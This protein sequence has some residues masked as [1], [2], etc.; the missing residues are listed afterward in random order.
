MAKTEK[1]DVLS[2]AKQHINQLFKKQSS[3]KLVY[4]T[5]NHTLEI[6]DVCEDMAQYYELSQ[7]DKEI[8]MLA[9][10]FQNTGYMAD[11]RD[12]DN[13]SIIIAEDFLM[14]L[15]YP[16]EKL[17]RVLV[18]I[19][20]SSLTD[21][22]GNLLQEILHDANLMHI[23]KKD[24]FRKGT[25]LRIE[26]E[27]NL[28]ESHTA[29]EWEQIELDFLLDNEFFTQYAVE[30]F[31]SRRAKNIKKQHGNLLK[32]KQNRK[33]KK[34]GKSFGRGIETLYRA[35]YRNHINLSSIADAKANMM[36]SINTIIMSVIITFAGTGFTISSS[37]MIERYRFI[38][39]IMVLL[40]A[41]LIS[42]VFAV[43]SA[44]PKVTEKT[45]TEKK[46]KERKSS[47]LFFGNFTQIPL[48]KFVEF[49][50]N[51]K[52]DQKLLYDNMSVDIY[53]LGLVLERKYKLLRIS[54]NTFMGGLVISVLTF[55]VIFIYT[56]T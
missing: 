14:E 23:G 53:Y 51:F 26:V 37:M 18:L 56:T 42:V 36:I 12:H 45:M 7:R 33:K 43:L 6:L 35:T 2:K 31:S 8:L 44:R 17:D 3:T 55:I 21:H 25:L 28:G 29:S 39:P 1:I 13:E 9:A 24:F 10:C 32:S 19:R 15:D 27:Q 49:L 47:V 30:K 16:K 22:P 50:N 46:L 34:A 20:N 11:Y 4:H 48:E 38:V 52:M 54:Y 41:S 5:Y 40:V